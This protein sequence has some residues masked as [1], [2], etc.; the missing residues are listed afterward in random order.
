MKSIN[1]SCHKFY[2]RTIFMLSQWR[3]FCYNGEEQERRRRSLSGFECP[4]PLRGLE[5]GAPGSCIDQRAQLEP[6]YYTY[7]YL[8]QHRLQPATLTGLAECITYRNKAYHEARVDVWRSAFRKYHINIWPIRAMDQNSWEELLSCLAACKSDRYS[9]T[10]HDIGNRW[11][12]GLSFTPR[13]FY[14]GE[15]NLGTH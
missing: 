12:L 6:N 1:T 4:F 9:S 15:I 5:R 14:P 8:A 7:W 11:R 10:I 13:P 2:F 3:G